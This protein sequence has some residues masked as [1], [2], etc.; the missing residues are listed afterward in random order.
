MGKFL[1]NQNSKN[2][3]TL[4]DS[5]Q[6]VFDQ[7][8]ELLRDK[9]RKVKINACKALADTDSKP[10]IPNNRTYQ[11]IGALVAVAEHDIDG[12]VRNQLK[13]YEHTKR[14]GKRLV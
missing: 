9:R 8:L 12:M 6:I 13:M 2:D 10:E 7:L 3:S 1:H 11:G 14:M 4:E 5:N